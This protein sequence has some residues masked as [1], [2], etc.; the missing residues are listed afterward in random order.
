MRTRN[1]TSVCP[2]YRGVFSPNHLTEPLSAPKGVAK[3]SCSSATDRL[4][5]F[6][7]NGRTKKYNSLKQHSPRRPA[8]PISTR[9]CEARVRKTAVLPLLAGPMPTTKGT[10]MLGRQRRPAAVCTQPTG[11]RPKPAVA[12]YY[13]VDL[14]VCAACKSIKFCIL[15]TNTAATRTCGD[16]RN[17][18]WHGCLAVQ[19]ASA[20]A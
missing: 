19:G 17:P 6:L 4:W 1:G 14:K 9:A 10:S 20:F 15:R 7:S 2:L 18:E 13:T 16:R 8:L 3:Y 11:M 5:C 12:T